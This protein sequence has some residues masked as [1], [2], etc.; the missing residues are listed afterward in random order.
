MQTRRGSAG[1]PQ[2]ALAAPGPDPD[3]VAEP[4]SDQHLEAGSLIASPRNRRARERY[5][6]EPEPKRRR[7]RAPR[8][9]AA[10]QL[11]ASPP[12]VGAQDMP[13]GNAAPKPPPQAAGAANPGQKV[14]SKEDVF[15]TSD[16][17]S[18]CAG[19]LS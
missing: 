17:I 2:G 10:A 13:F 9:A 4:R 16:T 5:S 8:A 18:S 7:L 3:D 19:Q 14:G 6:P 15:G 12:G 1:H 11:P